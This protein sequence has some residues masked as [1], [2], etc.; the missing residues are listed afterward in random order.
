MVLRVRYLDR[1]NFLMWKDVFQGV[2]V[3]GLSRL[4][5]KMKTIDEICPHFDISNESQHRQRL[6]GGGYSVTPTR[7]LIQSV[8]LP[9]L[10]HV[11][12]EVQT[13]G[14]NMNII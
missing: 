3:F 13:I 4:T 11:R 12:I 2:A 8:P 7:T 1:Q 9:M 6:S 5:P 10:A 14:A